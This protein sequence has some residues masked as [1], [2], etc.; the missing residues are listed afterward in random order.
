[1]KASVNFIIFVTA[2]L[3]FSTVFW[4][5]QER[6]FSS[7]QATFGKKS[8]F[9][10]V[11][12]NLVLNSYDSPLID[13]IKRDD[14]NIF[15][16]LMYTEKSESSELNILMWLKNKYRN[17]EVSLAIKKRDDSGNSPLMIACALGRIEMTER[18]VTAHNRLSENN[19]IN[20][21]NDEGST[22]LHI[23]IRN[24]QNEI[25]NILLEQENIDIEITNSMGHT[26]IVEAIENSNYDMVEVICNRLLMIH[27]KCVFDP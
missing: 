17:I 6:F 7:N 24:K 23:A 14:M 8:I 15:N 1:M 19:W 26:P 13:A 27:T 10:I 16:E 2:V 9:T 11:Q 25:S 3:L 22:A 20:W 4:C 5:F 12:K 18:L 21:T